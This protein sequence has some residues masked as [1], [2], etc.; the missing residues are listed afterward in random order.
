MLPSSFHFDAA[1]RLHFISARPARDDGSLPRI[2]HFTA[3]ALEWRGV[4]RDDSMAA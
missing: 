1:G 4:A 3:Q 2:N